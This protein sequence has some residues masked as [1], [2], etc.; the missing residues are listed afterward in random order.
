MTIKF[1][2]KQDCPKCP[3]A[4]QAISAFDEVE[5]YNLDESLGLAE[6]AFYSVMSTPSVVIS[7][8][9]GEE[10]ATFRGEMPAKE[11]ISRWL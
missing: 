1:F 11:E 4:K 6:A 5:Y 2:W 8:P 10:V 3:S 7:D 9:D